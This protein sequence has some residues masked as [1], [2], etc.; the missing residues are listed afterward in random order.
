M[1][2][3][4]LAKKFYAGYSSCHK[5]PHLSGLGTGIKTHRNGPSMAGLG[6]QIELGDQK[7]DF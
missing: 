5:P 6:I 1:H 7:Q 3:H 2:L 4:N